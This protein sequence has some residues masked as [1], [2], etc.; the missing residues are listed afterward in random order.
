MI[1]MTKVELAL[2]T[3]MHKNDTQDTVNDVNIVILSVF[4]LYDHCQHNS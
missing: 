4:G 1:A 3:Q 2:A